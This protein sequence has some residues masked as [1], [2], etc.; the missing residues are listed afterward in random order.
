M[1][2]RGELEEEDGLIAKSMMR[3]R[4]CSAWVDVSGRLLGPCRCRPP[5]AVFTAPDHPFLLTLTDSQ[6]RRPPTSA[7]L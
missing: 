6:P 3:G 1:W 2:W 7:S 5:S 4:T